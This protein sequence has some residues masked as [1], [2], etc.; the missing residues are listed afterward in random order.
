MTPLRI[1]LSIALL[2]LGIAPPRAAR[3]DAKAEAVALFDRGIKELKAG[4]HA[5]ACELLAA[6]NALVPDSGTRGSLARCY[7]QLGRIASAWLLWRELADTAPSPALR[8]DAAAQARKLE[9]RLARYVVK[10]AAPIEGLAL[11]LDGKPIRASLDVEVPIDPGSYRIS[12]AA[13]G[14]RSHEQPLVAAEGQTTVIEIPALEPTHEP[15]LEPAPA[16]PAAP[17]PASPGRGRKIAAIAI[18]GLGV[19][20]LVAGSVF[21]AQASSRY[22]DAIALCGGAIDRCA[23]DQ[24]AAAQAR[25]DDARSSA[26]L[27]TAGFVVGGAAVVTGIVLFVTAPSGEHRAVAVAPSVSAGHAGLTISGAF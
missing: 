22:D 21:G 25:V 7:T 27:S 8:A 11:T 17:A 14:R 19:A 26:A 3:A 12:A 13:P 15:V 4:N 10:T 6:S 23:V 5:K 2:V 24:L 18:G 9:P 16:P 1:A 20:S